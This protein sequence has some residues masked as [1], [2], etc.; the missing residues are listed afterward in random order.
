MPRPLLFLAPFLILFALVALRSVL[1][2]WL[3][4]RRLARIAAA[5]SASEVEPL[6]SAREDAVR[7][8]AAKRLVG[9]APARELVARVATL[10]AP[11]GR[12]L[13]RALGEKEPALAREALAGATG[14]LRL[15]WACATADGDEGARALVALLADPGLATEE[16]GD[17]LDALERSP[18]P[19]VRLAAVSALAAAESPTP[20]LLWALAD[21]GEPAD[22]H[23]AARHVAAPSFPTASTACEAVGTLLGRG[24]P[25]D[26]PAIREQLAAGRARVRGMHPRGDN[27]LA[28]ELV[29]TLEDLEARLPAPSPVE[30]PR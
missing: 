16:R 11:A 13:A 1:R 28:D 4:A 7:D 29:A 17:A 6:L 15:H 24:A 19:V 12:S 5:T 26:G 25:P 21:T 9:L 14:P 30:A 20:E 27:P 3:R 8:A 2:G 18:R 22:A 10:S 23:L